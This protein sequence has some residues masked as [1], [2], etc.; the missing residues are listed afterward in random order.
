MNEREKT[1]KRTYNSPH[2]KMLISVLMLLCLCLL[3]CSKKD[4]NGKSV[5]VRL[6]W[7]FTSHTAAGPGV[8]LNKGF[9]KEEGIEA[10][11]NPGGFE[12]DPVTLVAS[13]SDDFGIKGADDVLIARSKGVPIV[14]I[15]M[16]Y[17]TNPVCFMTLKD[18]G[19][20]KAEDFIGK[21]VGVKYGQNV[22]TF[23]KAM[24]RR[25]KIDEKQITESPVKF[26]ITPLLTRSVDVFPGYATYEPALFKNK[27]IDINVI[28]AKDYGVPA[29]GNVVF[30]SEK[31]IKE[32]PDL[33]ERFLRAYVKGWKYA[34]E[35]PEKAADIMA[36]LNPKVSRDVQ[37][38]MMKL[39]IPYIKPTDD[40]KIGWM[41]LEGWKETQAVM[42]EENILEKPVDLEK[43]FTLEFLQ[44]IY[45]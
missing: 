3:S 19:I 39:T 22:Y 17:Q 9:F 32:N 25:L 43:A 33:V 8:A 13:G 40:F 30:T 6:K 12:F 27:G 24:L 23:Y 38:D 16:D 20:T 7:V 44:R 37:L 14:A 35:Y 26:D 29:Y 15:A 45:R 42:L 31:T 11:L 10:T 1:M 5:S 21:K 36:V 18:S 34:V 41:T 28:L 2:K 4:K